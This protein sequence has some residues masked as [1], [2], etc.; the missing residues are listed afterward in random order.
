MSCASE[1]S[2]PS[3]CEISCCSLEEVSHEELRT[4]PLKQR[5]L[6]WSLWRVP[7]EVLSTVRFNASSV[8]STQSSRTYRTLVNL[9]TLKQGNPIAITYLGQDEPQV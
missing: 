3:Q 5:S 9:K 2:P 6:T 7:W 8:S 4:T 1:P